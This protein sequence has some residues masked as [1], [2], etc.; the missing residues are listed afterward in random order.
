MGSNKEKYT[1]IL[2][3]LNANVEGG[4]YTWEQ[5]QNKMTSLRSKVKKVLSHAACPP[6]K[7]TTCP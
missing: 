4:P 7:P 3:E 5:C 2:D 6:G 1:T